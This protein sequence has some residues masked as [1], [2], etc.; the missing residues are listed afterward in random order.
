[1]GFILGEDGQWREFPSESYQRMMEEESFSAFPEHGG[2]MIRV[3][4]VCLEKGGRAR[5]GKMDVRGI[6]FRRCK[7]TPRGGVDPQFR[8]K[9]AALK[10]EL[11]VLTGSKVKKSTKV[12]DA[13]RR[14]KERR[15]RNEFAW[16]P[17]VSE[18]QKLSG[19]IEQ[20]TG[21]ALDKRE[22]LEKILTLTASA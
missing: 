21:G 12:V 8:E 13:A 18:V 11:A 22:V 19:L 16:S 3:A 1:M 10:E 6:D 20:R 2:K 9:R 14:F 17:S 7:L 4:L 5:K 15:Y